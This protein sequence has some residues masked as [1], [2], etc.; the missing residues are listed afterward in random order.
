M[1][2][3]CARQKNCCG[4]LLLT[5]CYICR[6]DADDES[7]EREA[8]LSRKRATHS[9]RSKRPID[10]LDKLQQARMQ[11]EDNAD[12]TEERD[13]LMGDDSDH[14]EDEE[15][16]MFASQLETVSRERPKELVEDDADA[17]E[18]VISSTKEYISNREKVL[19]AID[20]EKS[21]QGLQQESWEDVF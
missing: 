12:T 10:L 6:S 21:F 11:Q 17:S 1:F 5:S 16:R 3:N 9:R 18:D 15:D 7:D 14:D 19:R 2:R 4:K 20:K 8:L 13:D